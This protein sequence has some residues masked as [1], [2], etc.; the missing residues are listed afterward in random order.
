MSSVKL[1]NAQAIRDYVEKINLDFISTFYYG[2]ASAAFLN[3]HFGVK[4]KELLT[5]HVVGSLVRRHSN[6]FTPVEDAHDFLPRWL[7]V[8]AA[9]IDLQL[10]PQGME[11]SYLGIA[12]APGFN[13]LQ[14]P[15][16]RYIID[17]TMEKKNEE[18][19]DAI[20]KGVKTGA[21]AST[22][23]LDML[24]NGF[25]KI[26]TD[27]LAAADPNFTAVATGALT[28]ADCVEQFELVYK[29]LGTAMRNKEVLMYCSVANRDLYAESY[30]ENYS[31]NYQQKTINGLEAIRLD[32]GNAWVVPIPG[33]ADSNRIIATVKANMIPGTDSEHDSDMLNFEDNHRNI[34][35][36]A[37]FKLGAQIGILHNKIIRVNNQ[38]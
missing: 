35:M 2:F 7:E 18:M 24:F 32:L 4:G 9:K 26:I 17:A 27:G 10:D 36:W 8:E 34:D 30:R 19:E 15:F 16:E 13:H 5:Q 14:M 20:W 38:A 28:L 29:G 12:R 22:D 33:M 23:T 11:K 37:D 31:K 21:P 25:L 3:F 6:P 1:T